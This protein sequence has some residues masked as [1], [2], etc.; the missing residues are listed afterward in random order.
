MT[1]Q[2]FH[3]PGSRSIRPYW[4]LEEM[5][6]EYELKS[7]KYDAAYFA[8]DAF[9]AINPMGK[10]PALLDGEQLIVE[11]TVIMEYILNRHGPSPLSVAPDDVEYGT[12]LQWLHMSECGLSHYLVVAFGNLSPIPTYQVSDEFDAYCRFQARKGF[13]M[14]E[15]LLADR[16]FILQRGFSAADISVGFTLFLAKYL[17]KMEISPALNAYFERL[18][19]RP[20]YKKATSDIKPR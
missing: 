12:Y 18:Q 1:L 7:M 9:R 20:A 13:D 10:V 19:S 8:S 6:V 3:T 11:S 14:L 2:L 4:L 16:E 17:A 15:A 5:G